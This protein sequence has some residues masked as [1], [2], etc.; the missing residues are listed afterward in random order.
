[1]D[2]LEHIFG[3]DSHDGDAVMPKS[4]PGQGVWALHLRDGGNQGRAVT[5]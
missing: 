4:T 5:T 2:V 3:M 1:V